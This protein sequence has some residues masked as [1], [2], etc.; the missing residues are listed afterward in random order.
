MPA[1]ALGWVSNGMPLAPVNLIKL[2]GIAVWVPDRC[3]P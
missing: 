1:F 2:V 3:H